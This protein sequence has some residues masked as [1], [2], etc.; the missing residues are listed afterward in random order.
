M[1]PTEWL[2][3]IGGGI[4]ILVLGISAVFVPDVRW[5][6][7]FQASI[8]IAAIFL[9]IR[10]SRWGYFIGISAA[11]LWNYATFF[12]SPLFVDVWH[13]L[14]RPDVL[15]QGSGWLGNL[16]III[17]SVWAYAWRPDRSPADIGRF[18]VAF[19]LT[20]AW[21]AVAVAIFS[22]GRLGFFPGL[23]HARWPSLSH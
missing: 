2:I 13:R 1:G 22:P 4:F 7:V 23:L 16:L 12:T 14:G 3:A 21:L 8:Y 15:I 5:L 10:R 9:S 19:I 18:V 17:G 11:G 20:T 6:H